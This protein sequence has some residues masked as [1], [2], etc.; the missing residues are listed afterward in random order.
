MTKTTTNNTV[1]LTSEHNLTNY[2][3]YN[4]RPEGL[5]AQANGGR[6][7]YAEE[8]A[9][10][11]PTMFAVL[12]VTN[13]TST[14]GNFSIVST[15]W[16]AALD[17][18]IDEKWQATEQILRG[19]R[20][21][22][23]GDIEGNTRF[24]RTAPWMVSQSRRASFGWVNWKYQEP[25]DQLSFV[26][27]DGAEYILSIDKK[28]LPT[29]QGW[30]QVVVR[31]AALKTKGVIHNGD[32]K[33]DN[34]NWLETVSTLAGGRNISITVGPEGINAAKQIMSAYVGGTMQTL[35]ANTADANAK[36]KV[37][38]L[39][40]RD[41]RGTEQLEKVVNTFTADQVAQMT[42]SS[43]NGGTYNLSTHI[44][45]RPLKVYTEFGVFIRPYTIKD[46]SA[47]AR[48]ET[49]EAIRFLNGVVN[50]FDL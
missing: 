4:L 44:H 1:T 42:V 33:F 29:E 9:E 43:L 31:D 27:E 37:A 34:F 14:F 40:E 8:I 13:P 6:Q 28:Y 20:S 36:K 38:R 5:R 25:R 48:I 35:I 2:E 10:I 18:H 26:H 30:M 32:S 41:A 45:T 23:N 49:A 16:D 22:L 12:Q 15:A 21:F 19:V 47:Q 3:L 7:I 11:S 39:A 46:A 50:P 17:L 24:V